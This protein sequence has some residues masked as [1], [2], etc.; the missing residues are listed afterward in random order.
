MDE[1]PSAATQSDRTLR[2]TERVVHPRGCTQRATSVDDSIS[3]ANKKKKTSNHPISFFD[4]PGEMRN[5]IYD[6]VVPSGNPHSYP[7]DRHAC[8]R[9][10][11]FAF[12]N[13]Q[14]RAESLPLHLLRRYWYFNFYSS[15][16][17]VGIKDWIRVIEPYNHLLERFSVAIR[18]YLSVPQQREAGGYI[19][20]YFNK[21]R[22]KATYIPYG[23]MMALRGISAE[24]KHIMYTIVKSQVEDLQRM[25]E[26][27]I[28]TTGSWV[29]AMESL[30]HTH[31]LLVM[32]W[33]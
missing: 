20:G 6:F 27:G 23:W 31:P 3:I 14:M 19:M 33:A 11:G 17:I 13:R 5:Q 1:D 25:L 15:E 16:D 29:D 26:N 22:V 30:F 24:A 28:F 4:L 9:L 32:K 8:R 10:P 7:V 12:V 18:C 21:K 2:G